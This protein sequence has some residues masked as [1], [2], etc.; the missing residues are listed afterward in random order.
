M[1]QTGGPAG[2]HFL[3]VL[4]GD[5]ISSLCKMEEE[6]GAMEEA[7]LWPAYLYIENKG[8]NDQERGKSATVSL[9]LI[10]IF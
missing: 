9:F 7:V 1:S 3:Q 10:F 4:S 5:M 2:W 8:H 6:G